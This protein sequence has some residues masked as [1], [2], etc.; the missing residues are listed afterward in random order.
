MATTTQRGIRVRRRVVRRRR[1]AGLRPAGLPFVPGSS[2]TVRCALVLE[3]HLPMSSAQLN[4]EAVAYSIPCNV[5][6]MPT[7]TT[8]ATNP[9][10]WRIT[11]ITVA[12]EPAKS[13][14]TQ[15]AG[16]GNA[17]SYQS[18]T[19]NGFGNVFKKLRALNYVRRSAPGGNL[20]VRW[21]I[22]MDWISAS[23]AASDS[24]QVPSLFFAVTN[25]GVI[26]TK[27]GDSEA[28][29]EWELELEFIVGG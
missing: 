7:I 12:M 11:A 2:R 29:L 21:P 1:R 25:P 22:N 3:N 5:R 4:Q 24:T 23:S 28:W 17:D 27:Q 8:L 9:L 18:A 6:N 15:I 26:E 14:S 20:Q 19:F 10:F 13:T 16:V